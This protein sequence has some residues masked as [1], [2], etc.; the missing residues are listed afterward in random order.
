MCSSDLQR[1]NVHLRTLTINQFG[2]IMTRKKTT[3]AIVGCYVLTGFL[4]AGSLRAADSVSTDWTRFRG[5]AG[6]GHGVGDLPTKWDANSVAWSAELPVQ[7]HSSPI[8]LGNRIFLTGWTRIDAGVE[9]RM[10][11]IDRETGK[12]VWNKIVAVADGEKLHNMN[13]WATPSCA[14]DGECVVGFFGPGGL[15]C[16][17]VDGD[18]LWA[19][20]LGEFPGGWGIGGSPIIYGDSIIQN[21]DAQGDSFL[22][23]VNKKTG[24]DIWRTQRRSKPRG[25]WSTP[26]VSDVD[27]AEEGRGG[28]E[29]R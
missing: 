14:T 9:R 17:T 19:R 26:I 8:V 18:R 21:C 15:H 12:D 2:R 1:S 29:W 5:S 27:R 4:L 28:K 13:S 16:L 6:T 3:L 7:G 23:A 24:E 20:S 11:C 10:L 25:G 22:L